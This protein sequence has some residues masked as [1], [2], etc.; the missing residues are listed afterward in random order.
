MASGQIARPGRRFMTIVTAALAAVSAAA[1]VSC[2]NFV[3]LL[4]PDKAAG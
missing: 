2:T 4:P 1:I 3:Q